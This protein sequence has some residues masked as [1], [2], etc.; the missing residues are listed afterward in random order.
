M[1]NAAMWEALAPILGVE[2]HIA[3]IT[4]IAGGYG[5]NKMLKDR[6]KELC[7]PSQG[8]E[9]ASHSHVVSCDTSELYSLRSQVGDEMQP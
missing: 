5:V 1:P 8:E 3:E 7:V 6:A 4:G 2:P 9:R